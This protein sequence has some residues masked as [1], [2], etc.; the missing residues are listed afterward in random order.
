M[1]QYHN[2]AERVGA[3]LKTTSMIALALLLAAYP[4]ALLAQ[5]TQQPQAPAVE[6]SAPEPMTSEPMT[7]ET[8]A[9][10]PEGEAVAIE[11]PAKPIEGQ[12]VLQE[13][14]SKLANDFLGQAVYSPDGETIGKIKDL[15]I[16]QNGTVEGVVLGVGGFLGIGE[17]A[18]AVQMD[19]LTFTLT[20]DGTEGLLLNTSKADL[21]S[22]PAFKTTK[23][24]RAEAE[25][26][27]AEEAMR[28]KEQEGV[29]DDS[30]TPSAIPQPE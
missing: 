11:T 23:Q 24:Q 26:A 16:D 30:M 18:V 14:S 28:L 21:D 9:T 8:A 20:P 6:Q 25:A 29:M 17:K 1:K 12:I 22:A 7:S 10:T 19:K 2:M 15:I 4:S 27:E 3:M 13:A 5:T